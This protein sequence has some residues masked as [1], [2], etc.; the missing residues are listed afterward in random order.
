VTDH[1]ADTTT[2]DV[3]IDDRYW[4]SRGRAVLD[5]AI[6]CREEAAAKLVAGVGWFWTVYS[7]AVLATLTVSGRTSVLTAVA[8]TVPAAFL[9]AAYLAGLRVFHPVDMAFHPSSPTQIRRQYEN[10]VLVKR[11]RLKV[12]T[13]L[14][15]LAGIAMVAAILVVA[16]SRGGGA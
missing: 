5:G 2:R 7:T 9:V 13:I 10:A 6:T 8:L 12:A 14:T 11:A 16:L 4:L 15:T 1:L 3:L